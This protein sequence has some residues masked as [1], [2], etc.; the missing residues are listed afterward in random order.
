MKGEPMVF[1]ANEEML[2][3]EE[4]IKIII[5]EF[6]KSKE[7]KWMII[8]DQYYQ[9]ENDI[10]NRKMIRY[11]EA[12]R[13][14]V[15]EGKANNRLC[16][17]FMH[18]FVEDKI[19]YLLS[20][21]Y[22]LSVE[23]ETSIDQVTKILGENFQR[24]LIKLGREASNKGIA[25]LLPYIGKDGVF[26]T[27]T[28]PSE[29]CIPV[30][31][32]NEHE[33]LDAFLYFY[34]MDAYI[35]KEKK[36]ITKIE[37]YTDNGVEFYVLEDGEVKLDSERYLKRL[38]DGTY[39]E[40]EKMG[41][42][43]V[44]DVAMSWGK[45]PAIPFKN[46]DHELPDIKFIKTLIDDY[47]KTRSDISNMLEEIR[48]V[49]FGLKGYGGQNLAEF[50]R[51]LS[52][53]RAVL[54]DEDG[55]IETY[56]PELDIAA[57]KEHFTALKEDIYNLGQAVNKSSDRI[58]SN[59]SGV[60]LKFLYSGLDLKCNSMESNFQWAFREL[61][62]FVEQYQKVIGQSETLQGVSIV[63]NRD[64][65]I[66]ETEAVTNCLQSKGVIS[67]KTIIENHPF[68]TDAMK[69]MEQIEKENQVETE[70]FPKGVGDET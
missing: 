14:V 13:P 50:M 26:Q 42:F 9:V 52:Y 58:G 31:S 64:I 30:W 61:L 38:P 45:I 16:H 56:N 20:R 68:V 48:S 59:S 8:G 21:P 2:T 70:M 7:R 44:D 11:D 39:T 63:F 46:N 24:K 40:I 33:Q 51:D 6:L 29:Q 27:M 10:K 4:L 12:Q 54:L 55:E 35:G 37:Y 41:H 3:T 36:V 23:D 19:N 66:N 22:T 69:E 57:A 47:D 17:S 65:Q 43:F 32:N 25:W 5:D 62:Y 18:L 53:Y 49:V 15:D 60:A 1:V 34:E 28:I 67:N